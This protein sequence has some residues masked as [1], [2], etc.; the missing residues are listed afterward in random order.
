MMD[1]LESIQSDYLRGQE[2]QLNAFNR[3][4]GLRGRLIPVAMHVEVDLVEDT[5]IGLDAAKK[6]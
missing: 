6:G 1:R 5:P 4:L 2:I 3:L